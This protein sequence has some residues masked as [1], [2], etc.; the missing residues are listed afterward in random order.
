MRTLHQALA[1]PSRPAEPD[2]FTEW[3]GSNM[4]WAW[5]QVNRPA[6][7]PSGT[8]AGSEAPAEAKTPAPAQVQ[9]WPASQSAVAVPATTAPAIAFKPGVIRPATARAAAA[10]PKAFTPVEAKTFTP[11]LVEKTPEPTPAPAASNFLKIDGM[12]WQGTPEPMPRRR[13]AARRSKVLGISAIAVLVAGGVAYSALQFLPGPGR[14]V[15]TASAA[16][17]GQTVLPPSGGPSIAPP[18]PAAAPETTV[19]ALPR[20]T[21]RLP[22]PGTTTNLPPVQTVATTTV[23]PT[24]TAV[25][26]PTTITSTEPLPDGADPL[27]DAILIAEKDRVADNLAPVPAPAAAAPAPTVV[28][29]LPTPT[30]PAA[31]ARPAATTRPAAPVTV[32]AAQPSPA[33]VG[34]RVQATAR[35]FVNLRSGPSN[36][37]SVL[38]V[39]AA[40]SAVNVIRCNYWCQVEVEGRTGWIYQDFLD[41][42]IDRRTRGRVATATP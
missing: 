1:S 38:T 36:G 20:S 34:P 29:A 40:G 13:V 23:A 31:P 4:S 32:A 30:P 7:L 26:P 5:R 15:V 6:L 39:V 19:A 24:A 18:T 10:E 27:G 35:D 41:G 2:G 22:E 3:E 17:F 28:A 37:S 33:P 12:N 11:V 14:S 9:E 42:P 8:P 21:D 16:S 25:V